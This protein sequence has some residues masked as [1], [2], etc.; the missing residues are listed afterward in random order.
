MQ[1]DATAIALKRG[2][3]CDLSKADININ[4]HAYDMKINQ[5]D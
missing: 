3:G 4:M 2:R 5:R 1:A